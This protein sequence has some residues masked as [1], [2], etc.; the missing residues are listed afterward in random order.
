MILFIQTLLSFQEKSIFM[1]IDYSLV[2]PTISF[3][4]S[5]WGNT[6][7]VSME[8]YYAN[9]ELYIITNWCQRSVHHP[10]SNILLINKKDT[11]TAVSWKSAHALPTFSSIS[12]IGYL[13]NAY[14]LLLYVGGLYY[15]RVLGS[16]MHIWGAYYTSVHQLR[17]QSSPC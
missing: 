5:N 13:N 10:V 7:Q 17:C 8:Y 16:T 11:R 3:P 4:A 14:A 1:T 15:S 9:L 2:H 6:T 12:Y